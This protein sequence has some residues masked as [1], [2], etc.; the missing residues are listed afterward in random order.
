MLKTLAIVLTG[1]AL[2]TGCVNKSGITARERERQQ[3]GK[4]PILHLYRVEIDHEA[5]RK[6]AQLLFREPVAGKEFGAYRRTQGIFGVSEN[7]FCRCEVR[8]AEL[9]NGL[10][11]RREEQ[12]YTLLDFFGRMASDG[13]RATVDGTAAAPGALELRIEKL[14]KDEVRVQPYLNGRPGAYVYFFQKQG[15][16]NSWVPFPYR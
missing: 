6:G 1:L 3:V 16:S 9:V 11:G 8:V 4:N 7:G 12:R 13:T 10:G 2:G 15:F 5:V 14:G